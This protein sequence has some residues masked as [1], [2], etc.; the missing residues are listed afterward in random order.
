MKRS[1]QLALKRDELRKKIQNIFA[2]HKDADG[3]IN[4][5]TIPMAELTKCQDEL[6]EIL[7]QYDEAVRLEKLADETDAAL[8]AAGQPAPGGTAHKH[9]G[10]AGGGV[11]GPLTGVMKLSHV[12]PIT[13]FKAVPGDPQGAAKKA[14][15]F[16]RFAAAVLLG[17]EQS[18]A[19]CRD[20]NIAI[21]KA[22]VEGGDPTLGGW[23]VPEEF[24]QDI[25]DLREQYGVFRNLTK[26]VPMSSDTRTVSRRVEGVTL[27][28]VG[29]GKA[30][31]ASQI[32]RNRVRLNAKKLAALI[33]FSSELDEDSYVDFGNEVMEEVAWAY[34]YAEDLA[35]FIGD[36]TSTYGGMVGVVEKLKAL[37]GGTVANIAGLVVASGNAWSEIT[38]SDFFAVV[39]R[40]PQYA[41][42]PK[43]GWVTS[44]TF[45]FT[46]M[47]KLA[48]AAGGTPMSELID[49]VRRPMFLG[50]PVFFS[51]VFPNSEANSQVPCIFGDLSKA[52]TMGDRRSLSIA[53]SDQ[54]LFEED[55]LLLRATQRFDINVHDVGNAS[56]TAAERKPGP[57][58]GLI[59]ADS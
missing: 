37:G 34:A 2:Q 32:R 16:G 59:T 51:Q 13:S 44:R 3:N 43:C 29:E 20:N 7:N 27:Y 26:V 19:W 56:A 12:A 22:N 11:Q 18:Q 42:T 36:G 10:A 30:P 48:A 23:A 35:G 57:V 58:V 55:E 52:S 53:I 39:G 1:Q 38:L 6:G 4:H 47:M 45:Y 49:G 5:E 31:T 41:D 33:P 14:Y 21:A 9:G 17:H 54:A 24:A 46:V 15:R 40:L 50:Y 8:K 25:I 28:Y